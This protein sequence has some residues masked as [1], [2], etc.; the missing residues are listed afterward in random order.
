MP[1]LHPLGT[2]AS[3]FVAWKALL[4]LVAWSAP[5]D[6]Y[7]TCTTLLPY[8][9][10]LLR[11][12]AIYFTHMAQYGHIF[13]QEWAF[14]LGIST[15]LRAISTDNL[16]SIVTNGIVFTHCCHFIS[17]LC[18]WQVT[19]IIAKYDERY[20]A[21]RALPFIACCLHILAP[22]GMFLSAP[23]TESPFSALNMFG[24][25][26]YLKARSTESPAGLAA[27]CSLSIAA[28][29]SFGT[30]TV[31]R[32]NGVLAGLPFL[33]DALGYSYEILRLRRLDSSMQRLLILLLSTI[34]AGLCVAV[35][36]LLPQY[37]AYQEYCLGTTKQPWCLHQL[38]L[39]FSYV[40]RHYW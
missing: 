20:A 18:L 36:F 30:A 37:V 12:D 10:K 21:S 39:V 9:N 33:F 25:W 6:G 16:Q 15:I 2:I 17:V 5:G 26:L 22:A 19:K 29:V 35:G 24:F 28:G 23:Y 40:Q 4:L 3:A 11:W 34:V 7:D 27:E 14:G 31:I 1:T 38:P 32:S 8:S 13:E